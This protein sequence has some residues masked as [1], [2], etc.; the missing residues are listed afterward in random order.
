MNFIKKKVCLFEK[1]IIRK[2][3]GEKKR[4]F[5]SISGHNH[6]TEAD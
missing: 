6:G 1:Q 4:D 2:N 3:E 5:L